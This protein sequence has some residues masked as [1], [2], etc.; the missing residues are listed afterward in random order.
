[1]SDPAQLSPEELAALPHDDHGNRVQF[2]LWFTVSISAVFVGLRVY[3]K[4]ITKRRLWWDDYLLVGSWICLVIYSGLTAAAVSLYGQGKHSYDLSYDDIVNISKLRVINAIFI[5]T[6]IIWSKCGFAVTLLRLTQGWMR[7]T[8]W[9]FIITLNVFMGFTIL[10]MFVGCTPV[11]RAW[12][13]TQEG[14]CWPISA[15]LGYHLFSGA[16]SAF[17]DIALALLPWKLVWG[18]QMKLKEK[19]GVGVAMSMG[20]FA[21][22]T[23]LVKTIMLPGMLT[24]DIFD[25]LPIIYWGSTEIAT[26]LI[27]ASIPVLRVLI[28][29]AK[30]SAR[31]YYNQEDGA[32]S[33]TRNKNNTVI[34]STQKFR[35]AHS[36]DDRSD[37]SILNDSGATSGRVLMTNEV[38]VN[39]HDRKEDDSLRGYEMEPV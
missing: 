7:A 39:Y 6:A 12:D 32:I 4:R 18:L 35:S 8:V 37:K 38:S 20:V 30:S 10:I 19:I 1:M 2:A 22:V 34:I 28:R 23:S 17:A 3:C 9:F 21:G 13:I 16:Y 24:S 14:E 15:V 25:S 31:K 29:D 33:T 5:V 27:A 36:P 11:S 26:C